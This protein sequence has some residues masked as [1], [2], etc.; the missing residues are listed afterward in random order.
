MKSYDYLKLLL[1]DKMFAILEGFKNSSKDDQAKV[2]TE[3]AKGWTRDSVK[4]F[5]TSIG[6]SPNDEG[7]FDKCVLKFTE[8]G[9]STDNANGLCAQMLDKYK[10]TTKW[11]TGPK[12]EHEPVEES[13]EEKNCKKKDGMESLEEETEYQKFFMSAMKKF[14]I[15]SPNDFK[16]ADKKTQFFEYIDKNWKAV[17]EGLK[18]DQTCDFGEV[19]EVELDENGFWT[20]ILSTDWEVPTKLYEKNAEEIVETLKECSSSYKQAVS[21]LNF[22]I[23]TANP[24]SPLTEELISKLESCKDLLKEVYCDK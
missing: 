12:G 8:D 21:R 20:G 24:K 4:K 13:L 9:M 17:E 2:L 3:L 18:Y 19:F 14:G 10:G 1:T 16:D 11:R 23:A 5:S 7:F 6:T 15:K 22:Y